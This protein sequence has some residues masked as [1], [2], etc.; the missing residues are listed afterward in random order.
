MGEWTLSAR[1]AWRSLQ[2]ILLGMRLALK[3][4]L[5]ASSCAN[6]LLLLPNIKSGHCQSELSD[7]LQKG[8]SCRP[9]ELKGLP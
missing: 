9:V 3:G 6:C 7:L 1:C 8:Q 2:V 5:P 4:S